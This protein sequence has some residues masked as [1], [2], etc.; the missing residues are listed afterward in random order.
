MIFH[1]K[2]ATY[3]YRERDFSSFIP[4]LVITLTEGLLQ[5]RFPPYFNSGDNS[6][7]YLEF[8]ISE[9]NVLIHVDGVNDMILRGLVMV[10]VNQC[11]LNV[12]YIYFFFKSMDIML[13]RFQNDLKVIE[14]RGHIQ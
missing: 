10:F 9:D 11:K 1:E 8:A 13:T 2:R 3:I 7:H 6:W 4:L 12:A 5:S 14:L